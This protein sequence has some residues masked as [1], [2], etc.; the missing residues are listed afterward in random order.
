[1]KK[2]FIVFLLLFSNVAS[3]LSLQL[4]TLKVNTVKISHVYGEITEDMSSAFLIEMLSTASLP[5][6]RIIFIDSPGGDV[7][8]GQSIINMIEIEKKAGVQM[9]CAVTGMAASMAFNILTHCD[10]RMATPKSRLLFHKVAINPPPFMRLTAPVMLK[11][12]KQMEAIDAVFDKDNA[13]AMHISQWE[14]EQE[15]EKEQFTSKSVLLQRGYLQYI[16]DLK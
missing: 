2:A 12:I 3:A 4:P 14:Y 9:V 11:I 7:V 15:A 10:V 16:I 6:L 8:A 13:A 1:M 5:G